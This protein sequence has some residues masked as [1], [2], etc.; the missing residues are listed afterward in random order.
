M[1]FFVENQS[2]CSLLSLKLVAWKVPS[3]VEMWVE[4]LKSSVSPWKLVQQKAS[5]FTALKILNLESW[6][7]H[8]TYQ[9]KCLVFF[10]STINQLTQLS[11]PCH[12]FYCFMNATLPYSEAPVWIKCL[13]PCFKRQ[14]SHFDASCFCSTSEKENVKCKIKGKCAQVANV[15][16]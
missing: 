16:V 1:N 8:K 4:H 10:D 3:C 12:V 5:D 9:Y 7:M 14:C 11:D 13:S 6:K 2:D 15:A